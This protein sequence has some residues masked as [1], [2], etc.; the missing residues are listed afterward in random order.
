VPSEF[1]TLEINAEDNATEVLKRIG[2]E[3]A[4]IRSTRAARRESE[5]LRG[6][7]DKLG[8]SLRRTART[9]RDYQGAQSQLATSLGRSSR[10]V[11]GF[12]SSLSR[13]AAVAGP[14]G[15][16]FA[17]V[18]EASRVLETAAR[19][20]VSPIAAQ[21]RALAGATRD[22]ARFE[23]DITR[24][25]A[26]VGGASSN[27][28]RLAR[29]ALEGSSA[30]LFTASE[31]AGGLQLLT[32]AGLNA[33]QS[34]GALPGVLDLATAGQL[35][36]ADAANISTNV[37]SAYRLEVSELGRV[38][39]LL[40]TAAT[41]SN[42]NVRQ[43][44][45]AFSF[46][47]GVASSTNQSLESTT[48]ILA[49]LGNAG[50]N[51]TR[52]GRSTAQALSRI[53]NPTFARQLGE[54]GVET[55]N[56]DG[57][58]RNLT[59]ILRDIERQGVST[60]DVLRI[61][62]E[63][64]GRSLVTVLNQGT[65]TLD[66][67][68]RSLENSAGS[69]RRFNESIL[70]TSDAAERRFLSVLERLRIEAG[71]ELLPA[72]TAVTNA[73]T[74]QLEAY[75]ATGEAAEDFRTIGTDLA[76][77]VSQVFAV[78]ADL[79]PALVLSAG[80]ALE[81]GRS[82]QFLAERVLPLS[83]G[84][85]G[86]ASGNTSLIAE[87]SRRLGELAVVGEASLAD[88][89]SSL[90]ASN[91]IANALSRGL[92]GASESIQGFV[93]AERALTLRTFNT[94]GDVA[95]EVLRALGRQA[96]STSSD[97]DQIQAVVDAQI[98]SWQTLAS[99]ISDVIFQTS[100]LDASGSG[101]L[102]QR[103]RDELQVARAQNEQTRVRIRLEQELR[104]I[105]EQVDRGQL[106]ESDAGAQ[107]L[108]AR[109]RAA[110]RIVELEERA[111][112][113]AQ[114]RRQRRQR[115]E[116]R[117]RREAERLGERAGDDLVRQLEERARIQ[118]RST[119]ALAQAAIDRAGTEGRV[120]E[121]IRLQSEERV[122]QIQADDQLTESARQRLIA[123]ER[124][125][126]ARAER[127]A[128]T[129]REL[130]AAGAQL[131]A[132]RARLALAEQISGAVDF[133]AR[134]RLVERGLA[135]DI[136]EIRAEGL[137]RAEE[138]ARIRAATLGAELEQARVLT[139]ERRAQVA[140]AERNADLVRL[141]AEGLS[142]ARVSEVL[143]PTFDASSARLQSQI[144]E[145]REASDA[146]REAG[147][148]TTFLDRRI[149]A[150]EREAELEQRNQQLLSQRAELLDRVGQATANL[151]ATTI[152]LNAAQ[153][154]TAEAYALQAQAIGQLAGVAGQI[155][156]AFIED[157]RQR[158]RVEAL[159]QGAASAAALAGFIASGGAAPNLLAASI[160]HGLAAAQ[161]AVVAGTA[162]GGRAQAT[163]AGA[164]ATAPRRIPQGEDTR[165][166]ASTR[167]VLSGGGGGTTFNIDLSNST[168]LETAETTGRRLE[169][170]IRVQQSRRYRRGAG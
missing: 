161:F 5:R 153:D 55:Q 123:E 81:A 130:S 18:A 78:S 70:A 168:N 89:G 156:G 94:A 103:A 159:F 50:I 118:E 142:S 56:L 100:R 111:A 79:A 84:L 165:A 127:D 27:F 87:A 48:A 157:T 60:A 109:Q 90:A 61:F 26:T 7:T 154:G 93:D 102:S 42:T 139:D 148:D 53:I 106:S 54:L 24:V 141:A 113:Q 80:A 134:Q 38:N 125:L 73:L 43:L 58:F 13:A 132:D 68:E 160:Q 136:A 33:T 76:R 166:R 67:Y 119:S 4:K 19:L 117:E 88:F 101:A 150:L 99:S 40:V 69:A 131:T 11:G 152:E 82:L 108:I 65:S 144:A 25:A 30:T 151:A 143:A 121:A 83:Q 17:G 107:E 128:A 75:S 104:G 57:S 169:R 138:E 34:V 47:A 29:A 77:V 21:A 91:D 23:A 45:Q 147:G 97:L 110:R 98:S 116:E 86:L 52:A 122:R 105:Q 155:A 149:E 74:E 32:Q 133:G 158:A 72:F 59:D 126:A 8:E 41:S 39:D 10:L 167:E 140:L 31:A 9:S 1:L 85:A 35:S 164:S 49:A 129:E 95:V 20:T 15:L 96:S 137:P 135:Q 37:L 124:Y 36:L 51:A 12:A 162:A 28:D 14:A 163:G 146:Q 6:E 114:Q 115:D 63:V 112:Q 3:L 66:R 71:T 92:D 22:A 46:V 64:G 120:V 170:V 2:D 145:L 62:G 16:A 44:G